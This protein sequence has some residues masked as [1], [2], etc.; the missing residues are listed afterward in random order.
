MR[1]KDAELKAVQQEMRRAAAA[2]AGGV[3]SA[4]TFW[5]AKLL[6][7]VAGLEA[8]V[9]RLESLVAERDETIKSLQALSKSAAASR[10]A[11][12]MARPKVYL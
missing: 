3:D 9:A 6:A 4:R 10:F 12:T 11:R 5:E 2:A 7:D 8:D 1:A